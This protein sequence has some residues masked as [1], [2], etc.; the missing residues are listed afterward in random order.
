[1]SHPPI[2]PSIQLPALFIPKARAFRVTLQVLSCPL[3]LVTGTIPCT[4]PVRGRAM[5]P[6]MGPVRD[7][8]MGPVRGRAWALA[9]AGF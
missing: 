5:D 8:D 4:G 2:I 3:D 6:D 7:Q 1:M 9:W